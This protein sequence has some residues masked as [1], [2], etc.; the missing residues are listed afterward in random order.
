MPYSIPLGGHAIL[1]VQGEGRFKLLFDDADASRLH[2]DG[3][4]TIRT[5]DANPDLFTPPCPDWVRDV[6][7]SLVGVKVASA[8]YDRSGHLRI[9]FVDGRE[10]SVDDG[11]YENWHYANSSG[12]RLHGG[13]GSVS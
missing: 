9:S 5:P 1:D 8:R 6:L 13:A 2:L 12:I 7:L 11:P 4:F 3:P 10:L